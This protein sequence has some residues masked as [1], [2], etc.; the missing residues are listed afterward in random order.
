MMLVA[1]GSL[2]RCRVVMNAART[3][4]ITY[5][6]VPG[7]VASF[8]NSPVHVNRVK[9][10]AHMHDRGVIGKDSAAPLAAGKSD[11]P[12]AEAVVHAAVVAHVRTPVAAMEDIHA[13]FPAP[14]VRRP[15]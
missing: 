6:A 15:Q 2:T 7:D 1:G 14:V 9:A 4:A 5:V 12:I 10:H 13:V 11:A 3:A 8:H